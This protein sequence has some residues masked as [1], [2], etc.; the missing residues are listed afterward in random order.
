MAN[1][2]ECLVNCV[3]EAFSHESILLLV[4]AVACEGTI[5][6]R[7]GAGGRVD[8]FFRSLKGTAKRSSSFSDVLGFSSDRFAKQALAVARLAWLIC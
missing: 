6:F 1:N 4:L 7:R 2:G 8:A 3:R 5:E